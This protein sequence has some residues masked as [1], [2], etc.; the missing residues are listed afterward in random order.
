M[1]S[2]GGGGLYSNHISSQSG[3]NHCASESGD[4]T[5]EAPAAAVVFPLLSSVLTLCLS[6]LV[7][8]KKIVLSSKEDQLFEA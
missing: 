3:K 4:V 6:F 5:A 8:K 7:C 1:N 2:G